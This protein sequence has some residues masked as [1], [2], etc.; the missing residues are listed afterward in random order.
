MRCCEDDG[1]EGRLSADPGQPGWRGIKTASPVHERQ[2]GISA[3]GREVDRPPR[4]RRQ[5][6][7]GAGPVLSGFV[8]VVA[9]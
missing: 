6:P 9:P 2:R 3:P 5:C 1:G 7:A 8:P 4:T